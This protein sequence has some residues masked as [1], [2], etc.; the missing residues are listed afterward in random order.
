MTSPQNLAPDLN[1]DDFANLTPAERRHPQFRRGY[2]LGY[3]RRVH[4]EHLAEL[5]ENGPRFL[6]DGEAT[7]HKTFSVTCRVP[8]ADLQPGVRVLRELIELT[9]DGFTTETP[10][11]GRQVVLPRLDEDQTRP[12][13][14]CRHRILYQVDLIEEESDGW[15]DEPSYA[16]RFEVEHLEVTAAQHRTGRLEPNGGKT[17]RQRK[18]AIRSS[19]PTQDAE[20]T[21]ARRPSQPG[22]RLRSRPHMRAN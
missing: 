8:L 5:E 19:K 2:E 12:A 10:C 16:A 13:V 7:P 21:T 22:P 6:R 18:K 1:P 11:C 17:H 4:E 14:C 3:N 9:D 15:S 20:A